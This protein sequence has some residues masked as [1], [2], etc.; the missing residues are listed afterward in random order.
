MKRSSGLSMSPQQYVKHHKLCDSGS[1]GYIQEL[2]M[3]RRV[4]KTYE[5]LK[6]DKCNR[7][8]IWRKKENGKRSD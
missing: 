1:I 5:Q 7:Y 3:Q 4:S 6:C 2:N 8:H